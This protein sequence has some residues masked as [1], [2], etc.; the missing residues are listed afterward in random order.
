MTVAGLDINLMVQ[1]LTLVA[2]VALVASRTAL[3]APVI[4]LI[5]GLVAS[6][7]GWALSLSLQPEVILSLFLPPLLFAAAFRLDLSLLRQSLWPIVFLAVPGVLLSTG[8]VGLAVHVILDLPWMAALLCGAVLAATDSAAVL[9]LFRKAGVPPSLATIVAGESLFNDG[10]ALVLFGALLLAMGGQF[11]IPTQASTLAL[12]VMGGSAVGLALGYVGSYVT[13]LIDDHLVEMLLSTALAYGSYVG[14][15]V[16][17]GSGVLATVFAG[18]VLGTYGRQIGMSETT[19]R[20]LDDL[21]DYLAFFATAVLYLLI[22]VTIPGHDLLHAPRLVVVG[23]AA[24]VIA[25]IIVVYGLGP[26]VTRRGES[27]PV[28]YRHALFWGGPRGAVCV[29]AALSLPLDLPHRHDIQTLAYGAVV[30]TLVVQGVTLPPL[31]RF[32][33][34]DG[35]TARAGAPS[36]S[37]AATG[38]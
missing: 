27:L 29:A 8:M 13:S 33:R 23:T 18:L 28:A 21:W 31:M 22:G 14:A 7:F 20:L 9:A 25:R 17:G 38:T 4:L 36:S 10:T 35:G 3:A 16:L 6:E 5:V 15:T 2:G 34:L 11:S 1:V 30:L 12:E 19:K 32:L 37:L 26:L 24:V